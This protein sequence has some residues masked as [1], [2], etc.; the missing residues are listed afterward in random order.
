MRKDPVNFREIIE[1][2]IKGRWYL[3]GQRVTPPLLLWIKMLPF[4]RKEAKKMYGLYVTGITVWRKPFTEFHFYAANFRKAA[5]K[6]TEVLFS[7]QKMKK[8]AVQV[9]YLCS[10]SR[11]YAEKFKDKN[12]SELSNDELI[13][14]YDKV[15]YYYGRS[16][17]YGFATWFSF[18]LQEYAMQLFRN[19][20]EILDKMGL[21]T[22]AA[23]SSLIVSPQETLYVKKEKELS[24]LYLKYGKDIKE[25]KKINKNII[26]KRFPQ[27]HKETVKFLDNYGWVGYDYS[28]PAM[29]YAEVIKM[30]IDKSKHKQ[31][32]KERLTKNEIL[33]KCRFNKKEK[34]I[35]E[36]FSLIAYIKDLRNSSDDFV[37]FCLVGFFYKEIGKRIGLTAAEVQLLWP[38]EIANAL[39]SKRKH[40]SSYIKNRLNCYVASTYSGEGFKRYYVGKQAQNLIKKELAENIDVKKIEEIKGTIAF[41]G[42]IIGVAKVLDSF[43]EAK[44]VRKGDILVSNMTSPRLISAIKLAGAIVTNEGGLTCHAAIIA[45]ELKKPCIVGTK[46]ATQVL[47]D[48]DLVEVD[49]N[50]GIVKILKKIIH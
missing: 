21:T 37:H 33:R 43:K 2:K 28:G 14:I 47:K 50:K 23:F 16:L 30:I 17:Y 26:S 41:S 18:T 7:D 20:K 29:T 44:K 38:E 5:L 15:T 24:N 13:K 3:L 8:R 34:E 6:S 48:G 4:M 49:A 32:Q 12:I 36:T 25:I 39:R 27:L 35:F 11:K 9:D 46:I 31:E 22:E 42:K 10:Q 19:K 45:R 1:E 40:K